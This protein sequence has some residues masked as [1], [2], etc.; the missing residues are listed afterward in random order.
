M[1]DVYKIL[2]IEK[3]NDVASNTLPEKTSEPQSKKGNA[4]TILITIFIIL[5]I[6]LK[7]LGD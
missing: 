7:L 1:E 4:W 3:E 2:E 6:V 5:R